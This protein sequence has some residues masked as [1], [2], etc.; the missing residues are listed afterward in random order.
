MKITKYL[1]SCLLLEHENER[2]LFDPGS[3][4]FANGEVNAAE[5]PDIDY[6]VITHDHPDH[7]YGPAI[8]TIIASHQPEI[9]GNQEVADR[10]QRDAIEV[11]VFDEGKRQFGAFQL[12]ALPVAHQPILSEKVPTVTAFLINGTILNPGDSFSDDL[13]RF[14]GCELLFCPIMAPFLKEVEAF[15]F[16]KRMEPKAVFAVHDGYAKPYF[17]E[18]RQKNYRAYLEELGIGFHGL[19]EM[20]ESITI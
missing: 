18:A 19:V 20:G 6:L 14:K 5:L 10:L 13:L 9:I 4:S 1:H 15:E 7:L 16:M 2:L 12:E 11:T 17:V 8:R 3:F